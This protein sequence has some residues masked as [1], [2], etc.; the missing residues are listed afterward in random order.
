MSGV[1]KSDSRIKPAVEVIEKCDKLRSIVASLSQN[2]KAYEEES[3]FY[4]QNLLKLKEICLKYGLQNRHVVN[5]LNIVLATPY[6]N[7]TPV[8]KFCYSCM[9]SKN[10]FKETKKMK[11]AFVLFIVKEGVVSK[12]IKIAD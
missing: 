10:F 5:I 1:V 8:I 12:N 6:P 3:H 9:V 2:I 7:H 11:S 4:F